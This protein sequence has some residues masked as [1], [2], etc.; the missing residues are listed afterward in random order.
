MTLSERLFRFPLT[1]C[2]QRVARHQIVRVLPPR[3]GL[4]ALAPGLDRR[5]GR[6]EIETGFLDGEEDVTRHRD[7]GDRRPFAEQKILVREMLV[8]DRP[9]AR[10]GSA[11]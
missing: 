7:V 2:R 8:R 6:L 3:K 4:D 11:R 5:I 9:K 10:A 1:S